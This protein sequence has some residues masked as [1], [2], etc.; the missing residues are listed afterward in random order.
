M[1]I[2][3][4]TAERSLVED[5]TRLVMMTGKQFFEATFGKEVE[6]MLARLFVEDKNLFSHQCTWFGVIDRRIFGLIVAYSYDYAR[7]HRLNTGKLML[8][9]IGFF[10]LFSLIK[11]DRVLGKYSKGDFYLS[12]LAVYPQFRSMGLGKKLIEFSFH[13][14]RQNGCERIMLDVEKGNAVATNLYFKVGFEKTKE[15]TIK[16]GRLVFTFERLSRFIS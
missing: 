1:K 2:E 8:K 12:N 13:L 3:F 4:V 6:Q 14:A 9:Q 15:S 11:I 10:R 16:I 7:K 5:F